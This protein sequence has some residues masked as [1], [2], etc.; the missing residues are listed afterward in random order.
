MSRTLGVSSENFVENLPVMPPR[1]EPTGYIESDAQK[2]QKSSKAIRANYQRH[3]TKDEKYDA[4][5][6][7]AFPLF[8]GLL[9]QNRLGLIFVL[10]LLI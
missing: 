2:E 10:R 3:A 7:Q 8:G 6:L 9:D 1:A 4:G 5:E